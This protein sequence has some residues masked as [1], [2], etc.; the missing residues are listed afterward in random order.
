[1][2]DGLRARDIRVIAADD[3]DEPLHASGH[4]G[5]GELTDLYRLLKPALAIPVHGEQAHMAANA[6]LARDAGVSSTLTGKNGDL[7]YLS[8]TPG[9]RRRFAKVGRLAWCE[10]TERLVGVKQVPSVVDT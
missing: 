10:K 9:V 7:F 1:M 2:V 5:Q 6:R 4:P 3:S 8:P